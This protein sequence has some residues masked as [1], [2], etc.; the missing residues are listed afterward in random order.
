MCKRCGQKFTNQHWEETTAHQTAWNAGNVSVCGTC[1]AS[2]V[3]RK[4]AAAEAAD[5]ARAAAVAQAEPD[6][7]AAPEP[8]GLRGLFRWRA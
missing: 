5:V 2:D 1:H 4:Q 7:D 3:A 8:G 6:P